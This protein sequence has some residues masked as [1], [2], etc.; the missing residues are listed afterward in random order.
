[1]TGKRRWIC[2]LALVVTF[3][4]AVV[5]LKPRYDAFVQADYQ[6]SCYDAMDMI[7]I[8][9]HYAIREELAK[10]KRPDEIDYENLL[11]RVVKKHYAMTLK[12]DLSSDDFCR[13]GGHVQIRLDP[14]THAVSMSCDYPGHVSNY[15]DEHLTDEF[16]DGLKGIDSGL[17]SEE[18]Q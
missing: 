6:K 11:R 8:R 4:I 15:T 13:A 10:G 16:L 14:E 5:I 12:Q 9:Y 3:T 18:L 17:D 1:M 2:V 7:A